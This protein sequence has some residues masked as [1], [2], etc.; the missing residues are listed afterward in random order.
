M[1]A[2]TVTFQIHPGQM[3]AF[4]PLMMHNAAASRDEPGCRQFDVCT[5]PAR[6]DDVF[7]YEIYTDSAAFDAHLAA[8][9]FLTFDAATRALVASRT[10]LTFVTVDQ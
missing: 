7:L 6:P 4:M 10:L 5:D 8:S 3:V 9:H 2:V 1:F